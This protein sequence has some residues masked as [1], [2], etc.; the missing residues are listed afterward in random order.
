MYVRDGDLSYIV[1]QETVF[2]SESAV[3]TFIE[4]DYKR[5]VNNEIIFT[6]NNKCTE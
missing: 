4:R 1:P 3:K 6:F 2:K 5:A